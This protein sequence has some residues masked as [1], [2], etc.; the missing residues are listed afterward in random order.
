[1][2]DTP[3]V[4]LIAQ[5]CA[6]FAGHGNARPPVASCVMMNVSSCPACAFISVDPI[7]D[8]APSVR[9]KTPQ[10]D[11][12]NTGV[13]VSV[14]LHSPATAPPPL[15]PVVSVCQVPGLPETAQ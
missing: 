8:V 9:A 4:W 6:T 5:T 15:L 10:V 3:A 14:T 11:A 13:A 12:S 2:V 7:T 1:M